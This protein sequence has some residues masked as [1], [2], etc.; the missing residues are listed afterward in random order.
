MK[1]SNYFLK[2]KTKIS[3][4]SKTD[5]EIKGKTGIEETKLS[6]FLENMII[7]RSLNKAQAYYYN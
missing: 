2:I 6:L 3:K 1:S 7:Y 5:K 4:Y